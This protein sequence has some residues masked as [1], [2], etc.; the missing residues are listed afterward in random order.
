MSTS[1]LEYWKEQAARYRH[2]AD[3]CS[4]IEGAVLW[5]AKYEEAE[6]QIKLIEEDESMPDLWVTPYFLVS[7]LTIVVTVAIITL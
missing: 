5:Q 6:R 7:M 4:E 1:E 2:A 3:V